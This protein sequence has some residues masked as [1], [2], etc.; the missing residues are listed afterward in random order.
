MIFEGSNVNLRSCGLSSAVSLLGVVHL[1]FFFRAFA[2]FFA[3]C[4]A[5][6]LAAR[7]A[8]RSSDL[9]LASF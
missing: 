4:L 6:V 9:I 2:A 7:L 8:C 1:R 3:F 5:L